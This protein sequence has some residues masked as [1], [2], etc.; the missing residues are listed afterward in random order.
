M[1]YVF[2][3]LFFCAIFDFFRSRFG[4][5]RYFAFNRE[6]SV[7]CFKEAIEVAPAFAMAH[8]GVAISNGV[9]YNQLQMYDSMVPCKKDAYRYSRQAFELRDACSNS[10]KAL[11]DALQCRYLWP[12]SNV[13][14]PRLNTQYAEAMKAVY[15]RFPKD[16]DVAC[17]CAEACMQ[18]RPW[19]LWDIVTGKH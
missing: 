9:N 10:E 18:L 5:Q 2:A 11:I 7:A 16:S 4:E 6:E 13:E 17:L 8:W 19:Q 15:E 1:N 14:L 3:L 12:L